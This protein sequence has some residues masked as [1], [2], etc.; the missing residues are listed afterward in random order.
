[1]VYL[2]WIIHSVVLAFGTI[3]N[4]G[5]LLTQTLK[6]FFGARKLHIKLS[7]TRHVT[8]VHFCGLLCRDREW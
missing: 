8:G 5:R 7:R 1:M 6:F 3:I 2:L 4:L